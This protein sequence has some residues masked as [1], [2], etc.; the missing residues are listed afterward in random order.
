MDKV[1]KALDISADNIVLS[2]LKRSEDGKGL[3]IRLYETD[4]KET[5]VT[6][7][8]DVL[9]AELNTTFT[10]YSVN[11]YYLADGSNEW[12]EVLFSELDM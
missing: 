3:V 7:K 11:T 4:G 8:G 12:K 10:P 5:P 2:A 6:I 1:Y 9:P